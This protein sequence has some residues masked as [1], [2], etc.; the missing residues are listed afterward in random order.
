MN[1]SKFDSGVYKC[2][3]W[4]IFGVAAYELT[5]QVTGKLVTKL[6]ECL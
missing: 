5:V 2:E 1:L 6:P 3:S 4:N